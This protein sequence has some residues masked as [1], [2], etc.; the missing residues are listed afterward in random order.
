[1]EILWAN[2]EARQNKSKKKKTNEKVKIKGRD[3]ANK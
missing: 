3:E 2:K 1:M